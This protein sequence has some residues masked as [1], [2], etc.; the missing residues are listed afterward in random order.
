LIPRDRNKRRNPADELNFNST[1]KK[2]RNKFYQLWFLCLVHC[3]PHCLFLSI[4]NERKG[5]SEE[6]DIATAV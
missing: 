6:E 1:L 4:S 2:E 5:D 3:L